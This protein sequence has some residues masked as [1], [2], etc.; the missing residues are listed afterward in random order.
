MRV[1][2]RDAKTDPAEVPAGAVLPEEADPYGWVERAVW[3]QRMLETLRR[4]GPE[5]GRWYWL[6]DKVFAE[7]TLRAAFARV[8]RNRGA[9]GVDGRTVDA[10]GE[11]LEEEIA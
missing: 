8:A 4:G 5:G 9:A 7:K 1:N 3:T 11:R 6:H 2:M 10:F